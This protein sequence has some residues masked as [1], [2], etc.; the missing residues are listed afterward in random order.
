M[1]RRC[2]RFCCQAIRRAVPTGRGRG[3]AATPRAAQER[4]GAYACAYA[5]T[6]ACTGAGA[7]AGAGAG[8]LM[9]GV[10][11][12]KV[13]G[14]SCC[15][16]RCAR[17]YTIYSVLILALSFARAPPHPHLLPRQ[18]NATP[19][20]LVGASAAAARLV[21]RDGGVLEAGRPLEWC[22][23]GAGAGVWARARAAHCA[24]AALPRSD[25]KHPHPNTRNQ[26]QTQTQTCP[27]PTRTRTRTRTRFRYG[28]GDGARLELRGARPSFA[29]AA[30]GAV[31]A[32]ARRA[33]ALPVTR[34]PRPKSASDGGAAAG[35]MNAARG[36]GGKA[37]A[38]LRRI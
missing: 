36:G 24:G 9:C 8:V 21:T 29:P 16:V 10:H 14:A 32:A 25:P 23:V 38:F 5:C 11:R 37:V 28:V 27:P 6:S 17:A 20:A 12:T 18:V 3:Q 15:A 19:P 26:A 30:T 7:G 35:A 1:G 4:P 33:A 34:A 22:G 13:R 2:R 31:A